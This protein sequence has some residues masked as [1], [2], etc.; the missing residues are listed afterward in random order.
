MSNGYGGSAEDY[1]RLAD[2]LLSSG[3][4]EE[5]FYAAF[6][7]RAGIESR[8]QGYLEAQKHIS[9]KKKKGWQIA[10][11]GRSIE[12]AFRLGN[13]VAEIRV[14]EPESK[15]PIACLYYTPVTSALRM[16]AE[17]L[18]NYLHSASVTKVSNKD[19]WDNFRTLLEGI[20]DQLRDATAGALLGPPITQ[21]STGT[22]TMS[23]TGISDREMEY[24]LSKMGKGQRIIVKVDYTTRLPKG[25]KS[26]VFLPK[27]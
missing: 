7:L 20:S 3:K 27:S 6:E 26:C 10:K 25:A 21:K 1:L 17:K 4:V 18:G 15:K 19:W 2:R 11:L 13:K 14:Y 8:M 5:L 12:E 22:T 9:K 23:V 24:L 16:K